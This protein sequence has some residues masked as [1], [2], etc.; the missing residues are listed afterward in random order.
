MR[1]LTRIFI[2]LW[3]CMPFAAL[4]QQSP[5]VPP[6]CNQNLGIVALLDCLKSQQE[7]LQ[8][9]LEYEELAAKLSELQTQYNKPP[10]QPADTDDNDSGSSDSIIDR[11]NWFDQNLEV[12][13]IVGSPKALTAYARLEGREFRLKAGDSIRLARV[14]DVHS[15]GIDLWVSG[16][17]VSVGLS[18]RM[19][20]EGTKTI[21]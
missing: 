9:V 1:T 11:I 18:G 10:P 19:R 5:V 16:H 17:E 13:A 14:T 6:V 3:L 21:E 2:S 8:R 4:A 7:I 15:R 12:Y 20:L